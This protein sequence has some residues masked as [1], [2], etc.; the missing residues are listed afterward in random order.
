MGKAVL[1][2]DMPANC[3]ECSIRFEDEWSFWCQC[4]VKENTTDVYDHMKNFTKPNWCPLKPISDNIGGNNDVK[5]KMY[6]LQ[7]IE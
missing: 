1:I 6:L 2:L 5:G 4:K 7:S 3:A